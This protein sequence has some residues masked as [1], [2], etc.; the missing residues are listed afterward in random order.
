MPFLSA[1][2]AALGTSGFGRGV[3]VP[4]FNGEMEYLIVAGGGAG[5]GHEGADKGAAGGGGGGFR[6]GVISGLS[7]GEIFT[8]VVGGG[9]TGTTS[10][11]FRGG[12]G[13]GSSIASTN[14]AFHIGS[15]GGGG[16]GAGG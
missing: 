8:V 4:S 12:L 16:G 1:L 6:T 14:P 9:G 11:D 3:G 13:N 15:N 5:G 7:V 2:A 10:G